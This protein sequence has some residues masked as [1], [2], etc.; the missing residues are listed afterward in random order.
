MGTGNEPHC[1]FPRGRLSCRQGWGT[2]PACPRCGLSWCS[3]LPLRPAHAKNRQKHPLVTNPRPLGCSGEPPGCSPDLQQPRLVSPITVGCAGRAWGLLP[4][5]SPQ[6]SPLPAGTRLSF[7][8]QPRCVCVTPVSCESGT[9][10]ALPTG[11]EGM[12]RQLGRMGPSE[13]H[14]LAPATEPGVP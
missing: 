7:S 8:P 1:G 10:A 14:S 4:A 6:H 9:H 3:T 12:Q 2:T 13:H 5:G 11:A